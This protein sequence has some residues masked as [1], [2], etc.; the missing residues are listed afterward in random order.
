MWVVPL[1]AVA[2]VNLVVAL[3]AILTGG[4][5]LRAAAQRGGPASVTAPM[6]W[7]IASCIMVVVGAWVW[8]AVRRVLIIRSVL[9]HIEKAH[10]PYCLFS[11]RGLVVDYGSVVCPECGQRILLVDEGL[12]PEDLVPHRSVLIG[13]RRSD[14][15]VDLSP[16]PM[17][18]EEPHPRQG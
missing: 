18:P 2:G 12:T 8:V 5:I 9:H 16:I 3:L 6:V 1:A 14:P 4:I 7:L 11:L 13:P 10:C 17:A 15:P